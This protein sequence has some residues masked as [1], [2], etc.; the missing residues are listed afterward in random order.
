[1]QV[2]IHLAAMIITLRT[3]KYIA[4]AKQN[5]SNTTSNMKTTEELNKE[6]LDALESALNN[7][8]FNPNEF[9]KETNT[10]HRY[11]Q[12]E[13]VKL[14]RAIIKNAASDDYKFDGRNEWAHVT[15]K[16]ILKNNPYL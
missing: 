5:H 3:M 10:W 13:L 1:M 9:I 7:C 6:A 16:E 14:A 2:T 15:S 12:N 11:L 8:G 4:S